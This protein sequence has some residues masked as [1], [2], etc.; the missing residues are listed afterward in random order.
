MLNMPE[1]R[2]FVDRWRYSK[3]NESKEDKVMGEI[4]KRYDV[5][6]FHLLEVSFVDSNRALS[7]LT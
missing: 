6:I 1:L 4:N 3:H 5:V 7:R 2:T